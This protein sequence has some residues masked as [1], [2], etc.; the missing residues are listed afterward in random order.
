MGD[1]TKEKHLQQ[2]FHIDDCSL[3]N[4][5]DVCSGDYKLFGSDGVLEEGSFVLYMN[6]LIIFLFSPQSSILH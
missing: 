4:I 3:I 1:T 5:E 2:T 6:W